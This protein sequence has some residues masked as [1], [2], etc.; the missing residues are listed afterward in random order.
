MGDK[1][2]FQLNL[3]AL[4][5]SG[6][7]ELADRFAMLE[8]FDPFTIE[9]AKSGHPTLL[10]NG[11]AIHSRYSPLREA[12]TIAD[13]LLTPLSDTDSLFVI[14]LGL[15]YLA[16]A[17]LERIQTDSLCVVEP[18]EQL[19]AA[20]LHVRDL[21]EL[22]HRTTFIVGNRNGKLPSV[23]SAYE[24]LGDARIVMPTLRIY[25]PDAISDLDRFAK[26]PRQA[27]SEKLRVMVVGALVGGSVAIGRYVS[28]ALGELG[29][30]VDF[31]DY[32][33]FAPGKQQLEGLTGNENHRNA[34]L[35]QYTILLG[36]AILARA[37]EFQPQIVLFMAQSPGTQDALSELRRAGVPTALWFVEDGDLFEYGLQVAPLYDV[38]FHIQKGAFEER[39]KQAGARHSHYLP[40]AADPEIH[41]PI[42]LTADEMEVYGSD[43]SH[44][45][46]G[47]YN[48]RR[49][50]V[51]LT[52][53]D[54]KIWGS[55]WE[56][57]GLLEEKLQK[58]GERVDE[59]EIVRI[60]NASRIN[61]NLHSST[62]TDGVNPHGDFVNPRTFEIASCG[63]FQLVDERSLLT[64]LFQPGQEVV[65]FNDLDSCRQAIDYY[66]ANPDEARK[67]AEA[68]R[69]KVLEQHTYRH[70][71]E[72]A[73]QVIL[74]T[75][76]IPEVT[77]SPNT[78][79]SLVQEAG[80]DQEM[81]AF[82]ARMGAPDD[83]L[84][85]EGVAEKIMREEGELGETEALFL[86]MNEF[87]KW[88]KEKGVV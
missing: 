25:A 82:F 72:E 15:G 65:T 26:Q 36:Q 44:M 69:K 53:Y 22:I 46:A 16:E 23:H 63:G 84:T 42:Q 81:A 13:K 56:G 86:L 3:D 6:Q 1:S 55:D 18:Y 48:R 45:G 74:D 10:F 80:D 68:G 73:I 66:L 27:A 41:R 85:L 71:M 67:I 12:E 34:L 87:G 9:Q 76:V 64:E 5:A 50:F 62:Y 32:T 59:D 17:V 78:V 4:R 75:C 38:F 11:Q 7:L 83:V 31:L 60:Y 39:L 24:K 79:R 51:G 58:N 14:G 30:T 35:S 70:R 29:H 43:V 88:A 77:S 52:R 2:F 47:Y 21:R 8:D 19:F 54:L 33:P 28:R 57:A 20:T 61:L 40:L 37:E 49:F